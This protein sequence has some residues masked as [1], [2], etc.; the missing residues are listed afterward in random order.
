MA[1]WTLYGLL[2]LMPVSG[3]MTTYDPTNFGLF[4]IPACRDTAFAAWVRAAFSL[5]TK[6]LEDL[7]WTAHSFLGKWVAWPLVAAHI[8]AALV[9]HF[10][11]KDDVLRRMLPQPH[12]AGRES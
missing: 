3:Y 7:A 6:D 12:R 2:I 5:S 8:G 11:R 9:H 10:V 1:H 4:V